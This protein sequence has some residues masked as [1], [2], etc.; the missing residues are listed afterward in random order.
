MISFDSLD[1]V[2]ATTTIVCLDDGCGWNGTA[3]ECLHL[4][5]TP[6]CPAC[7][8]DNLYIVEDGEKTDFDL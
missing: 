4:A 1:Q 2:P 6:V 7:R 3:A 5:G 8:R